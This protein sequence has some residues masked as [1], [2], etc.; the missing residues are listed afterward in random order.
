MALPTNNGLIE[1]PASDVPRYTASAGPIVI[2]SPEQYTEIAER[3]KTIAAFRRSVQDFFRP[4]K[5]RANAAHKALCDDER[6]A[7]NAAE[8]DERRFKDSLVVYSREQERIRRAE[9]L[10]LQD[11]E[12]RREETR[13]LQEAAALEL[14]SKATGD[15]GLQ[16]LAE[17]IIDAPMPVMAV[18]PS[19]PAPPKVAGLS[20]REVCRGEVFDIHALLAAAI[21]NDQLMQ[22]LR[23]E[24]NQS[25]LD[26][27]ASSL[28]ERMK[29]PG[30][31]LMRDKIPITRTR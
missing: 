28:Q 21:T 23:I 12:R 4:H 10:R 24:P 3:L 11:E 16:E 26:H 17:A 27:A 6:K 13:R 20:Y 25:A 31:R 19:T 29:I 18:Q 5:E 8:A 9:Q 15:V 1:Y 2:A 30:V 14:E 22:Y 7:L